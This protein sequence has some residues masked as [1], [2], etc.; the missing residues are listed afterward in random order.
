MRIEQ[1]MFSLAGKVVLL[2]GGGGLI[3]FEA[4]KEIPRYG[5][6][7]V[8]G[9]RDVE[10]FQNK[11]ASHAYPEQVLTPV[12]FPLDISDQLSV[13]AFFAT[14]ADRFGRIDALIN[15]AWPRTQDWLAP[16]EEVEPESFYK[17]LCDHAGGFFLCCRE[18]ATYMREQ[19]S[20]AILNMGSI[21]GEVGPHFSI[22][23]GTGMTCPAAYPFIKGG[24]HTF[25]RYLAGYLGQHNIRVNCL[26]PGGVA[27]PGK[28]DPLFVPRYAEQTMLG[29][30]A[31]PQDIVGP[32]LF[33]VS[34]AARYVTGAVFFADG[35][36]TAW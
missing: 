24:I 15:N 9:T 7:L 19:R 3:G 25:T 30:M 17:N 20:G 14:V 6:Q 31:T 34:D 28:Q 32:M 36:W 21:Y 18:V 27:D 22:Y 16:F 1:S 35:G 5:A 33:L 2:T 29:R 26:S 4:V 12:A 10:A 23:E 13:G 8:V 11:L